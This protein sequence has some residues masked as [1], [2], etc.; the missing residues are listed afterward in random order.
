MTKSSSAKNAEEL[1]SFLL[2]LPH[3]GND[4]AQDRALAAVDGLVVG[5]CGQEPDLASLALERFDRGFVAKQRDDDLPVLRDALA[6]DNNQIVR[7]NTDSSSCPPV[8]NVR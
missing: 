7:Q 6:V 2:I 4:A 5:V 3:H 1:F 8:S